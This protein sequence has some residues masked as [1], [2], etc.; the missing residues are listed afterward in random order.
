MSHQVAKASSAGD[1]CLVEGMQYILLASMYFGGDSFHFE[2]DYHPLFP[3]HSNGLSSV[4]ESVSCCN[5]LSWYN[6]VLGKSCM[7]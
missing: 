4:K 7:L 3:D 6:P 2:E 1:K 5:L